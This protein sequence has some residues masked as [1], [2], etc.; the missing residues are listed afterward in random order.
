MITINDNDLPIEVAAKII[1][2]T[3][4]YEPTPIGEAIGRLIGKEPSDVQDMFDL[5]EIREISTYLRDYYDAS[6][7]REAQE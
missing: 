3:M 4:P 2:G 1:K 5:E 6:K 7:R